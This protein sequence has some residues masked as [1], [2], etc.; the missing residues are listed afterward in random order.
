M[1]L[2]NGRRSRCFRACSRS[3]LSASGSGTRAAGGSS[4]S[5]TSGTDSRRGSATRSALTAAGLITD[6]MWIDRA[7]AAMINSPD[8]TSRP[9]LSE[10]LPRHRS[11]GIADTLALVRTTRA[12]TPSH[13]GARH[14]AS[15]R[16][17]CSARPS[18]ASAPDRTRRSETAGSPSSISFKADGERARRPGLFSSTA[19]LT[20]AGRT[21]RSSLT[22]LRSP[23]W[24]ER[25]R[26]PR[27]PG[28]A[29][30]PQ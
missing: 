21:P 15:A 28:Q 22:R 10:A 26:R 18:R 11:F 30:R 13:A 29:P 24:F 25:G 6:D 17:C 19:S 5:A 20:P 3:V 23:R 2:G 27:S 12:R 8:E 4:S 9:Y 16:T 1:S 14:R 7:R